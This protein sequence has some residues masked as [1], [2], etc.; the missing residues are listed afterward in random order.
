MKREFSILAHRGA[1]GY[2]PENTFAAFD[3]ALELGADMIETDV[4]QTRDG[5][6]VLFHDSS[7]ERTTNGQ[8]LVADL[9]LAE[10]KGLDAGS[11][12]RA[13]FAGQRIPT[14]EEFLAVYG[15]RILVCFE[16][17]SPGVEERLLDLVKRYGVLDGL[18]FT[19]F[20]PESLG[21]IKELA[22][23][24]RIGLLTTDFN[25][26]L[27]DEVVTLGAVQICPPAAKLSRQLVALAHERRLEVRVWG[28]ESDDL[29]ERAIV[30]GAD[31]VTTNWPD[32]IAEKL[33]WISK[34]T[35]KK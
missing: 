16:I 27:I 28:A 23:E 14:V 24:A 19:S 4:R 30:M 33:R 11:W 1:S 29:V 17:K 13:E 34:G 12:F 35:T 10:L 6:L 26:E 15:K 7:M 9:T 3:K 8:G 22:P 31:G 25:E 20:H 5:H 32:K 2:A 21:R 18:C